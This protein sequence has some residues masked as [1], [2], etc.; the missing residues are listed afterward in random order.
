MDSIV[1]QGRRGADSAAR[2]AFRAWQSGRP[3]ERRRGR[4]GSTRDVRPWLQDLLRQGRWLDR[5]AAGR[6]RQ[7]IS[8]EGHRAG[9][10]ILARLPGGEEAW[11]GDMR[12][13]MLDWRRIFAIRSSPENFYSERSTRRFP[14][15]LRSAR[16]FERWA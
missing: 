4:L 5:R 11:Q 9:T 16:S 6:R 3:Q 12:T 1:D 2:P 13:G 8:G 14:F 7:G 10:R 15:R